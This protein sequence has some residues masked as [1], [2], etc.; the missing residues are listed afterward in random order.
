[1]FLKKTESLIIKSKISQTDFQNLIE[2]QMLKYLVV[3]GKGI[4]RIKVTFEIISR[5]S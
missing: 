3:V 2:N 5:E 1:M 4:S